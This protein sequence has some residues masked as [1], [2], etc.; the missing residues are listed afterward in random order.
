MVISG[1]FVIRVRCRIL[2]QAN[3]EES[4][5]HPCSP[6]RDA[7]KVSHLRYLGCRISP[8]SQVSLAQTFN[9]M[10]P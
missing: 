2:E 9:C 1:C 5:Y 7:L 10:A 8:Q 4:T 3:A 6:P